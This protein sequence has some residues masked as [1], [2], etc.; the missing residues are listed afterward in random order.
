VV[1]AFSP[2]EK[3]HRFLDFTYEHSTINTTT[4]C[5]IWGGIQ[6]GYNDPNSNITLDQYYQE[7]VLDH[8]CTT[9]TA[10]IRSPHDPPPLAVVD[11]S[12]L[13]QDDLSPT[14]QHHL[15]SEYTTTTTSTTTTTLNENN[16]ENGNGSK[17]LKLKTIMAGKVEYR[18]QG[19]L[20]G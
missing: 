15:P 3:I 5:V 17:K 10:A 7:N 2:S 12:Y 19:L 4:G 18:G 9:T 13:I 8:N 20:S 11:V 1:Y 14:Y 6:A 16:G